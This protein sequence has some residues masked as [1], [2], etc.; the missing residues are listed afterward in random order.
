MQD[1]EIFAKSNVEN[2]LFK[3][4]NGFKDLCVTP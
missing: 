3:Q 2:S 1:A 4:E